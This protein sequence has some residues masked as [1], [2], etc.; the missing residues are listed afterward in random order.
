LTEI[1]SVVI[2]TDTGRD[3]DWVFSNARHGYP[4]RDDAQHFAADMA[5]AGFAV[6][7]DALGRRHDGHPK[8]V[9]DLRDVVSSPVDAETRPGHTVDPLDHRPASVILQAYHEQRLA[10]VFADGKVF[11]IAFVLQDLGDGNLYF[12][13]GMA[14]EALLAIW[15][16]RMRVSMSLIGSLIL[17]SFSPAYQL[18]LIIPGTSPCSA[19]SRSLPRPKPNFR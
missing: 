4:L 3:D 10:A 6:G 2:S 1:R 13:D 8:S 15:A 16:F 19:N 9:H 11:D 12:E 18:A 7:H 14:T 17:I 5:G